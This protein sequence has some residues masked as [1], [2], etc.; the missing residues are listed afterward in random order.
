MLKL[1]KKQ[2][3]KPLRF[4]F[5]CDDLPIWNFHKI[6]ETSNYSYLVI[7]W[8]GFEKLTIDQ[9]KAVERWG[10]IYNEYCRLTSNNKAIAYYRNR[11]RLLW[12]ETRFVV[13]GKMLVQMAMRNMRAEMFLGY[14]N[15]LR[16]FKVPYPKDVKDIECIENAGRFLKATKNQIELLRD[17]IEKMT[18]TGE[19]VP[20][21]KEVVDVEHALG[22]NEIDTKKTSVSKWI[23]L[24]N[25]IKEI[26]EQQRKQSLK[27]S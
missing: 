13:C 11:Q 19:Y 7:D 2:E 1:F 4:Y 21:E 14:I 15:V 26:V 9:E 16:D 24:I 22:K 12:L 27:K 5:S 3:Q 8:D 23:Q 6:M 17:E 20:F 25:K 18:E 10:Q